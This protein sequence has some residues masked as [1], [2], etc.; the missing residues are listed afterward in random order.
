MYNQL[1]A[2]GRVQKDAVHGKGLADATINRVHAMLH[3]AMKDAQ[4]AHIIAQNPLDQVANPKPSHKP[5]QVLNEEQLDAFMAEVQK[6]E[7]WRDFFYTELTIG[8]RR[9]EICALKW[10]DFDETAGT[11]KIQRSAS[12]KRAGEIMVGETKTNRG[13]RK[14]ILPS[15]TANILRERKKTAL[16]EWIFPHP[17]HPEEPMSPSWAYNHMKTLL[18]R[19]GLPSIRFHDLRHTFAT[20]ALAS[21]VDAK[22]LASI[23]GHTNASFTL[24]TYTHVTGNMQRRAAEIVGDF[25]TDIFG[26][27]LK[28]WEESE[29]TARAQ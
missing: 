6:D 9:G 21:G 28:P 8:L 25:M 1:K 23:L 22:T 10:E 20:H 19:A 4:T 3:L 29:K 16:T 5:M 12:A 17:L 27:E 14:I 13:I 26:E 24:D 11:L 18:K 7:P 15:T 2:H